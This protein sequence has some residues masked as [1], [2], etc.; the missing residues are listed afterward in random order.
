MADVS[1][2]VPG[3]DRGQVIIVFALV[4]AIVFVAL[5]VVVNSAIY[6]ENV[7][8]RDTGTDSKETLEQR[9]WV[10]AEIQRHVDRTNEQAFAVD[11]GGELDGD[12]RDAFTDWESV[13]SANAAL[14]GRV[15]GV[16]L[17]DTRIGSAISQ[18]NTSDFTAG[19]E[20]EGETDWTLAEDVTEAGQFEM[21]VEEESLINA[22]QSELNVSNVLSEAF[23]VQVTTD[24][25]WEVLLYQ[26][27]TSETVYVFVMEPGS[28]PSDTDEM[29]DNS[30]LYD[31][32]NGTATIDFRNASADCEPLEFYEDEVVGEEHEVRYENTESGGL[33]ILNVEVIEPGPTVEGTYRLFVDTEVDDEP[34]YDPTEEDHEPF[35]RAIVFDADVETRFKSDRNDVRSDT[36]TIRWSELV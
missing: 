8:T 35:A 25:T 31:A 12:L 30:C 26:G 21:E 2:P 23:T 13:T 14:S 7:S 29:F 16:N 4:L 27:P 5:A 9:Q 34:Y 11:D 20:M 19:G 28:S 10:S 36:F 24:E 3:G 33:T 17:V 6:T 32:S 1:L 18:P 15:V 22:N